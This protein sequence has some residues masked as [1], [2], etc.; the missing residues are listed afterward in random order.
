M[1]QCLPILTTSF[2]KSGAHLIAQML[3]P[4]AEPN[5]ELA[6]QVGGKLN[7]SITTHRNGGWGPGYRRL[8][9]VLDDLKI[10]EPG[11]YAGGHLAAVRGVMDWLKAQGWPVIFLYRDL[12]DIAVSE[13][14]HIED[15]RHW[16][17]HPNKAD[18]NK[19]PTHEDRLKAVITGYK[20]MP[21]LRRR[22]MDYTGWL[23]Q[24]WVLQLTY[25]DL[26]TDPLK[27]CQGILGYILW[28]TGFGWPDEAAEL[29]VKSIYPKGSPTFR[30]GRTGDWKREFDTSLK[31]LAEQELGD[32][33]RALGFDNGGASK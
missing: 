5:P 18:L 33:C 26:R 19:L 10:L 12:R 23:N 3:R 11:Q 27:A 28:R 6:Q 17:Q 29:M 24:D 4:L 22:W 30:A 13:T 25:R 31:V 32:W 8:E 2:P 7:R 16:Q 1:S 20:K 9:H 15:G 21:S 14:Y